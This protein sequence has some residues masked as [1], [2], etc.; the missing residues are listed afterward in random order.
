MQNERRP[1]KTLVYALA[2]DRLLGDMDWACAE[3][4]RFGSVANFFVIGR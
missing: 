2:G 1:D 3:A 4:V